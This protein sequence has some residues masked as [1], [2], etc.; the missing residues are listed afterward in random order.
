MRAANGQ[1][2]SSGSISLARVLTGAGTSTQ[3][4]TNLGS[5][6]IPAGHPLKC[7][8]NRSNGLVWASARSYHSGGVNASMADGSV[9]FYTDGTAQAVWSALATRAGGETLNLP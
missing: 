3:T 4:L 8:Q 9:R 1:A 2:S 5:A 6:T 7:T